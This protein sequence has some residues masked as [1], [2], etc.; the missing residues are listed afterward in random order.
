MHQREAKP[1][2]FLLTELLQCGDRARDLVAAL[3]G[4]I[5]PRRDDKSLLAPLDRE[6]DSLPHRGDLLWCS[7]VRDDRLP[8]QGQLVDH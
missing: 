1:A 6:P 5:D 7:Q 3:R 4:G 2:Q 8:S